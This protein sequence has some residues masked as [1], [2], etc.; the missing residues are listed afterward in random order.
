MV[1]PALMSERTI[2]LSFKK[3][4][5]FALAGKR[6]C[7]RYEISFRRLKNFS[8]ENVSEVK[9]VQRYNKNVKLLIVEAS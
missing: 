1:L 9:A 8:D 3:L 5:L 2:D 6:R 4:I 7:R